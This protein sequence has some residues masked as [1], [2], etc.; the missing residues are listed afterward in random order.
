MQRIFSES[1]FKFGHNLKVVVDLPMTLDS[2]PL[3]DQM[4]SELVLFVTKIHVSYT[5]K[6]IKC[7]FVLN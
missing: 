6:F 4:M 1:N 2:C 7:I 5:L 3:L